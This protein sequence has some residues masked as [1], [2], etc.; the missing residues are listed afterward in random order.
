MHEKESGGRMRAEDGARGCIRTVAGRK[1]KVPV[2]VD[3]YL[4]FPPT[5][6]REAG[7]ITSLEI[8]IT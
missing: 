8:F 7:K 4:S 2:Q 3:D 6:R 1:D 5:P